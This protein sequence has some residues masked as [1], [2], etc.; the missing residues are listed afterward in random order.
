VSASC[1]HPGRP[2]NARCD[3]CPFSDHAAP[4]PEVASHVREIDPLLSERPGFLHPCD[5]GCLFS[6][7]PSATPAS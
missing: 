4:T 7:A 6:A 2:A 1:L 3:G 5:D